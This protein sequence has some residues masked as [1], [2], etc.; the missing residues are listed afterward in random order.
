MSRRVLSYLIAALFLL[1][2]TAPAGMGSDHGAGHDAGLHTGHEAD[3]GQMDH[4]QMD[5]GDRMDHG[6][7]TDGDAHAGHAKAATTAMGDDTGGHSAE[8][9]AKMMAEAEA[10]SAE[11]LAKS[12]RVE[13]KLGDYIDF[14]AVFKDEK[15]QPVDLKTVFDKPVVILPVYF[16]CTSICNFLQAELANVLNLTEEIPGHD[17]NVVSVSFSDDEDASHARTSKRNYLNLVKREINADNWYYLTGDRENILRLMDSLG[18]YFVKKKKNFYIHPN[19]MIVLARDGKIIRYL[20]GPDF[21]PFDVG[22]ALSE[23]RKG[24]PGISIK[25]GVLSFCFDYDPENK[26]YVFK[27]FRITGT[28]ILILVVGFVVFLIA[29]SKRK[30]RGRGLTRRPPPPGD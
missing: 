16:M 14:S 2:L 9:H 11:A 28:A 6:D 21:L 22:M 10:E 26:T 24:E 15:N 4:H 19:A 27:M 12:V 18:Y 29:P 7:M 13:E 3:H 1:A 20:Y 8:A 5:H 30:R 23:A 25:R 17:F